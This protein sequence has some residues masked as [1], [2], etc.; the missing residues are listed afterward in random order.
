MQAES[1][2]SARSQRGQNAILVSA[3]ILLIA[4]SWVLMLRQIQLLSQTTMAAYQ[5]TQLEIVRAMARSVEN[6]V[7]HETERHGRTEVA[8]F[9]QEIFTR[10][11][12]PVHLLEHGDAWIYAPD[13]VVFDRS[14]DFPEAY[15]GKS[16]AEIFALQVR[17][18]A[19]HYEEMTEAVMN[20]REDVGWYIWLPDKG[21]EVAAWTPVSVGEY[22]WII[23]LSTPLPEILES[24]GATA[25]IR[26][27][28]IVMSLSTIVALGLLIAWRQNTIRRDQAIEALR[29]SEAKFRTL[30]ESTS[31]AIF[32]YQGT[33]NR[34]V[35]PATE[36]ITGYS[37]AELLAMDFWEVGHPD[38][39]ELLKRRGRARQRGEP[40]LDQYEFKLL[41]KNGQDCW[42]NATLGLIEFEGEVA[43]LGTALDI[44]ARKQAE[45]EQ[46]RLLVAEWE[47]RLLAETL[48]DVFLALT[49]QTSRTAVLNEIL[50]QVQQIVSY[51]AA[52]IALLKED[53]LHIVRWQGYQTFSS[54]TW[55]ANLQQ[56]LVDFPLDAQVV[57]SRQ[58]LVVF[59]THQTPDWVVIKESAWIRSYI[60]VPICLHEQVLGLLRLD[61][62]IPNKFSTKD[63]ERLQPLAQAAAIAL[64]NARLHDQ[65]QQEIAERKQAEQAALALNHKLLALQYAGATIASRLDLQHVL[66][67][68]TREI[69][70][71]LEVQGCAISEWDQAADTVSM[72]AEYTPAEWWEEM[73]ETVYP[74][75]DFPLTKQVLLKRRAQQMTIGQADVDPAELAY[76]QAIHIKTLLMLSMEFQDRVVGLVEVMDDRGERTF[77]P[78]EIA[79]AQLLANQAATATENARLYDQAQR[80]IAE[81]IQAEQKLRQVAA[82]N[83]AILD[84]IPDSMFYLSREGQLLDSKLVDDDGLS[85]GIL[86]KTTAGENLSNILPPELVDLIRNYIAQALTSGQIQVFEYEHTFPWGIQHFEIRLVISG[87]NEVLVIIR[88]IT[89]RKQAE[90]QAIHIER[91]TALGQLAATLAHEI[92]N[93]LQAIQSHLDL[94]LDFPLEPGESEKYL[95]IIRQEIERLR[96]TAQRVLNYAHPKPAPRQQVFVAD[97]VQRVLALT[98]KKL[99]HRRI[100]V[101][102]DLRDV[103][104]VLAVPDHLTQIFMNLVINAI[105]AMADHGQLHIAIYPE[106]N[107][108]AISFTNNGPTISS[109]ILSHIFDPFFTT[110]PEGSGLG[111]WISHSLVQQHAG[112]L[113]V[114]NLGNQ[115]GVIFTV[116]L[117]SA[118]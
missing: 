11:I 58:P 65:A 114:E 66:N 52:N 59:D 46:Q 81:R 60:S 112:S 37:Q 54:E 15:R 14:S 78:D 104:P 91:L 62:E 49:A 93:P 94:I 44:T 115:Q 22:T 30:A 92:N 108:V 85:P 113:T 51:R 25:Q 40:V 116:K 47:Q 117:P 23:G 35:N 2:F 16:M 20:A 105:E 102:T 88:N 18:G 28:F 70:N 55:L 5:Q 106:G 97:L 32:I 76:M 95:E 24:T 45:L 109:E 43:V 4:L 118:A 89:Q 56:P 86:G 1:I 19:S 13:H 73:S 48:G 29:E 79:L 103:P 100:Q 10:F 50:R 75:A 98:N 74:L 27:S 101:S 90:R 64:E 38:Y 6:Y 33:K 3:V 63:V 39:Q 107:E 99:V 26:I 9:E 67:T 8:E 31:A 7:K 83:Q 41:T 12:D 82:K 34:Y 36:T 71:L 21:K 84:A 96:D 80:E 77:T 72:V 111:L 17:L 87:S 69:A 61:S 42:V 57:Q 110:K 68:V 53:T